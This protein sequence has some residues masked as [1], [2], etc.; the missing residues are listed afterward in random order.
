[1]TETTDITNN[2][3]IPCLLNF[4]VLVYIALLHILSANVTSET[5]TLSAN[6]ASYITTH[7]HS[8]LTGPSTHI[9]FCSNVLNYTYSFDAGSK[10]NKT[11]LN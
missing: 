6:M 3:H 7:L 5:P 9:P 10:R 1:M 2:K 11:A 4:V 8:L